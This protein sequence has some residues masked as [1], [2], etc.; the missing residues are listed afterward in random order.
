MRNNVNNK[1]YVN[2]MMN[3][4]IMHH[5][6][7]LNR[8]VKQILLAIDL[9]YILAEA[10]KEQY[11]VTLSYGNLK[12]DIKWNR[13][14]RHL[15][16]NYEISKKIIHNFISKHKNNIIKLNVSSDNFFPLN[17]N[18]IIYVPY[19]IDINKVKQ[20]CSSVVDLS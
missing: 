9:N 13:N 6:R 20:E 1:F 19:E 18:I 14:P 8:I 4:G 5:D 12:E 10:K 11:M 16:L 15:S 7:E 2:T 17:R 3:T